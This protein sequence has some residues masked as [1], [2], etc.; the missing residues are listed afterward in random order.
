AVGAPDPRP[1]FRIRHGSRGVAGRTGERQRH[2]APDPS[3]WSGA[4]RQGQ[5]TRTGR[6]LPAAGGSAGPLPTPARFDT[7]ANTSRRTCARYR[8]PAR[9]PLPLPGVRMRLVR[10][11]PAAALLVVALPVAA[12]EQ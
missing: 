7:L 3:C 10:F 4:E 8:R 11:L 6:R 5:D 12:G 1:D 9:R 2:G